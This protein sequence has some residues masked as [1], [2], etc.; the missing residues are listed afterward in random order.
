LVLAAIMTLLIADSAAFG[1]E[2]KQTF[3]RKFSSATSREKDAA[4]I[5]ALVTILN[6]RK[7]LY[8]WNGNAYSD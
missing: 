6:G 3:V 8:K 2:I 1:A 5:V 7:H 4:R